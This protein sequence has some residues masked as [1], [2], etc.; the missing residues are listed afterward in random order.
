MK[1]LCAVVLITAFA[2]HDAASMP[3]VSIMPA[4]PTALDSLKVKVVGGGATLCSSFGSYDCYVRG[5]TLAV[6]VQIDYCS[7]G[8]G[9][10]L[11]W[12]YT[13]ICNFGLLTPGAYVVEVN[14][15]RDAQDPQ[16][17]SVQYFSATV[18]GVTPAQLATWGRLRAI[19]R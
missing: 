12:T 1:V 3:R 15:V 4:T 7:G 19:Y 6:H 8:G 14:E 18:T 9:F 11:A 2:F 10:D 5:D 13:K 17:S 16:K